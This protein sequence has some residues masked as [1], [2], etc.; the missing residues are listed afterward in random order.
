MK[1]LLRFLLATC[2]GTILFLTGFSSNAW[3][4]NETQLNLLKSGV[5][6]WNQWSL[7]G[8][9]G[10]EDID[11]TGADLSGL[12]LTDAFLRFAD[13]SG[14]NLSGTN[15]HDADLISVNFSNANL[16]GVNLTDTTLDDTNFSNA[17]LT[18]ADFSHAFAH[19][20][21]NFQGANLSGANLDNYSFDNEG[22]DGVRINFY[23]ATY[24]E[25]TKFPWRLNPR[26]AFS[27]SKSYDRYR[28]Y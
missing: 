5:A 25:N 13:L 3:A 11:L 15:L 1:K 2:L 9:R 24:D 8:G 14:A 28:R 12:D 22:R 17:D 26:E 27:I 21:V 23:Q 20:F 7:Y 10:G 16:T 18:G 19:G 6:Q 4:Y